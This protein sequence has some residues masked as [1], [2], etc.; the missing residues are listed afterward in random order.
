MRLLARRRSAARAAESSVRSRVSS[1]GWLS[2]VALRYEP[3][4]CF[5]VTRTEV[6]SQ[7][8][9]QQVEDLLLA[10]EHPAVLLEDLEL[11]HVDRVQRSQCDVVRLGA[12]VLAGGDHVLADDDDRQQHQLKERLADEDAEG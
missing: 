2:S 1:A 7:S 4:S 5:S 12:R 6:R 3:G 10:L 8:L 11:L 9:L